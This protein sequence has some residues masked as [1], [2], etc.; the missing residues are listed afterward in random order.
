MNGGESGSEEKKKLK[1]EITFNM[2]CQYNYQLL[3]A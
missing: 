1:A 2:K 3:F